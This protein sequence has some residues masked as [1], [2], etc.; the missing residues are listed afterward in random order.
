MKKLFAL[1]LVSS[2]LL[3][4]CM[5][6][7]Q[8]ADLSKEENKIFYAVG[9][10][11]GSRFK[12]LEMSPAEKTAFLAGIK[13]SLNGEKEKVNSQEYAMKFRELLQKRTTQMAKGNKDKGGQFIE[14][15][16]SK[17]GGTKTA[18]GLAYKVLT[19]GKGETPKAEDTVT[20][21][22]K[23]TLLDGTEFDSSYSRNK[24]TSFPLNRVIKGWTEGL[25][26]VKKGGKIKLVIPSELAYGD[27]GAPPK[28]PG[29][30]TLVFE[31]ELIDI[32]KADKK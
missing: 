5:K 26:L 17:E 13:D 12:S 29:G 4:G 1:T 7:E 16:V 27:Q 30:A 22:Y 8:K 15:F 23:G 20:V 31:V 24:P 3:T 6:G 14:T 21:H 9:T 19:E 28:I 10:M 32:K 25:Q 18:S 11:H 2:A